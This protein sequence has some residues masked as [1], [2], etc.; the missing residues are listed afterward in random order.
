MV[1]ENH[2]GVCILEILTPEC[3]FPLCI[4]SILLLMCEVPIHLYI[5]TICCDSV[6][7]LS[8]KNLLKQIYLLNTFCFTI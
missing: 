1:E 6:D 3:C 7:L 5:Y 8:L 2:G 4:L